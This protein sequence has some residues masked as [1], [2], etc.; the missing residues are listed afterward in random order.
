MLCP[1]NTNVRIP[2]QLAI[3]TPAGCFHLKQFTRQMLA[4]LWDE[5]EVH[6]HAV[7]TKHSGHTLTISV[8][9]TVNRI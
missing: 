1:Y 9:C 8:Q 2:H 6:C 7:V 4:A 5:P 3:F